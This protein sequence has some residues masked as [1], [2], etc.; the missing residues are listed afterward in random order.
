MRGGGRAFE[1]APAGVG[2]DVPQ[3]AVDRRA[4]LD[5]D[6]FIF[7]VAGIRA[8]RSMTSYRTETD[9]SID[10]PSRALWPLPRR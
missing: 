4:G 7:D 5:R 3:A 10:P 9:P 2:G 6:R 1:R 8:A